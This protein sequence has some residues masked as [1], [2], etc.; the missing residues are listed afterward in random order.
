MKHGQLRERQPYHCCV[1]QSSFTELK[2]ERQTELYWRTTKDKRS[3]QAVQRQTVEQLFQDIL[4]VS[5]NCILKAPLKKKLSEV[6][7]SSAQRTTAGLTLSCK[8]EELTAEVWHRF[9]LFCAP[10]RPAALTSHCWGHSWIRWTTHP[11]V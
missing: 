1:L 2:L 4:Y 9:I 5:N 7:C 6:R 11:F 3:S 8:L 10:P